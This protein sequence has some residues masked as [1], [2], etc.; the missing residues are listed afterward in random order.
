MMKIKTI[1]RVL[2][3]WALFFCCFSYSIT[4]QT[5]IDLQRATADHTQSIEWLRDHSYVAAPSTYQHNFYVDPDC[6]HSTLRTTRGETV[7][8]NGRLNVLRKQIE[9]EW[10]DTI[11]IIRR[12]GIEWVRI[13]AHWLLP[14][15]PEQMQQLD[16]AAWMEVIALND[17]VM[18]SIYVM[19]TKT[20]LGGSLSLEGDGKKVYYV[21]Q[22]FFVGDQLAALRPFQPNRKSVSR[23][24]TDPAAVIEYAKAHKIDWRDSEDLRTL[25]QQFGSIH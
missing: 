18:I 13:G 3:G 16:G 21:R 20:E 19:D 23:L 14:T 25:L 11:R 1:G 15:T 8:F 4:A 5:T 9:Y 2:L 12:T 17:P 10:R 22:Q 6:Q 7:H 24:L